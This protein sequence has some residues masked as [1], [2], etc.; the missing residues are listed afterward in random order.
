MGNNTSDVIIS[1]SKYI[2]KFVDKDILSGPHAIMLGHH[3]VTVTTSTTH[4]WS[5][6]TGLPAFSRLVEMRDMIGKVL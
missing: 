3:G 2:R 5:R 1:C 6:N 4:G